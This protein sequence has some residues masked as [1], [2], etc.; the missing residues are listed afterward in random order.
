M[1]INME[2]VDAINEILK[3]LLASTERPLPI[4]LQHFSVNYSILILPR[5]H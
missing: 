3:T 5:T 2:P 1:K 4:C